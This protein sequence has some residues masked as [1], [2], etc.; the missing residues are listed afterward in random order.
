MT[1]KIERIEEVLAYEEEENPW[2]K[3]Y[4]DRVRFPDGC[5][6]RYNRIVEGRRQAGVAILPF[7]EG[8]VGLVRIFRYAIGDE[9]WEIPR[10]YSTG[11]DLLQD[12]RRELQEETGLTPARVV[13]LGLVH[14]SSAVLASV[15]RL[16]GAYCPD[17]QS[18]EALDQEVSEFRWFSTTEVR[19][20]IDSGA[21]MDS[22]TLAAMLR[23]DQRG[24]L[25]EHPD[26][27]P[28][29]PPREARLG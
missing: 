5:E 13:D 24:L 1:R 8:E 25:T 7:R 11:D 4:F 21:I 27:E 17:E 9:V 14:P 6:G 19:S 29:D 15:V 22:F 18:G 12:A 28:A 20:M 10:G 23:A 3:L 26:G 16:L 2:V